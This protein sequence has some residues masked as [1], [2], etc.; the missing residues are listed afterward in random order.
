MN[1]KFSL[2]IGIGAIVLIYAL[3]LGYALDNYGITKNSLTLDVLAQTSNSGGGG[4]STGGGSGGGSSTGGGGSS[5]GSGN[6]NN[7]SGNGY[8]TIYNR[9]S[10]QCTIYGNGKVQILGGKIIEVDGEMKFDGGLYC[11]SGG[12]TTCTPMECF[13]LWQWIF[14]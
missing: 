10:F 5:S 12:N 14:N 6:G 1:K 4:S 11:S 7:T 3:N 13:Q 8:A 9:H 2:V